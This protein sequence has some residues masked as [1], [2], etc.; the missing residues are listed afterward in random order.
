VKRHLEGCATCDTA[1]ALFGEAGWR[2]L[3]PL[4]AHPGCR[5]AVPEAS[6]VDERR[7]SPA[8]ATDRIDDGA[9]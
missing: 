7:V 2:H 5:V 9:A 1:I 8:R 4:T 3:E 6:D